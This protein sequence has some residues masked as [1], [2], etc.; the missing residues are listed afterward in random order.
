VLKKNPPASEKDQHP[1]CGGRAKPEK[2]GK[3]LELPGK[4]KENP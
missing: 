2:G 4:K 3:T 1:F